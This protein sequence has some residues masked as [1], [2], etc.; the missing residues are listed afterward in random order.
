MENNITKHLGQKSEYKDQYDPALLVPEPRINNRRHLGIEP[1]TK[2]PFV[3]YDIWNGYEVSIMLSNGVP[4]SCI[5]KICYPCNSP[6]IIESKSMKLYW[7][8]FN[9]YKLN[10]LS[11]HEAINIVQ[12]IAQ[13]DLRNATQTDQLYVNIERVDED[14]GY[15]CARLV[16]ST[17]FICLDRMEDIYEMDITEYKH[18]K[19]ILKNG[20]KKV[21]RSY[22]YSTSL[23]SLCKVTSQPDTGNVYIVI[24]GVNQPSP[25][26]L[27]KYIISFRKENHFHEEIAEQMFVSLNKIFEPTELFVGCFYNRRGGWDINPIRASS[28]NLFENDSIF[29]YDNRFYYNTKMSRQ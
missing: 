4:I 14:Y 16:D 28:Y 11:I 20:V 5:A 24:D 29:D 2:L 18:N 23:M 12:Q 17:Q 7:N 21:F 8:S 3:G 13:N 25:Q 1:N 15:E 19:S 22:Y 9:N 6:N 26:S 10:T 27:Y